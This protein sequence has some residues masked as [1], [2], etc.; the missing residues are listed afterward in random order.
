[1]SELIYYMQNG[2]VLEFRRRYR[3][4]DLLL[5]DDVQFLEGKERTQIELYHIFNALH[6][7]GK[8]VILS[9]DTPPKIL[10]VFRKD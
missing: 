5:I 4:V 8:Q 10:K 7:I 3:D 2:S 9:S 1:M 6:L